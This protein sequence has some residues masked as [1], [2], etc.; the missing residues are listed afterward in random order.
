MTEVALWTLQ[1]LLAL[2]FGMV[3]VSKTALPIDQL[4]ARMPWAAAF[5]PRTLRRIG[6]VEIA[7]ALGLV[8]PTMAGVLLWLTTAAALGLFLIMLLA[9]RLHL[10][11]KE[12]ASAAFNLVL[13]A[14][15]ALV[16]LATLPSA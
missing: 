7:G 11:R 5:A 13:A 4:I 2:L 15:M 6:A 10:Q 9:A 12:P 8:I 3:G 16:G 1:W 14:L